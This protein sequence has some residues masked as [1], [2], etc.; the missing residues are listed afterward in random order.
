MQNGEV[1]ESARLFEAIGGVNDRIGEM[2]AYISQGD[3]EHSLEALDGVHK[4]NGG[5]SSFLAGLVYLAQ[6]DNKKAKP[7]MKKAAS[8]DMGSGVAD[9]YLG[10][11]H[12][13]T[14]TIPSAISAWEDASRKGMDIGFMGDNMAN[15]YHQL[16]YRYFDRGN[17]DRVIK[18]WEKLL[19][20]QP[21]DD[22]TRM[23]LVHAYFLR[24]NDYAESEQITYAIRYWEKAWELDS[25]NAEIAHNLALAY[26]KRNKLGE[27]TGYWKAAVNGWKKQMS[28]D[29][30]EKEILKARMYTVHIHLADIALK[31]DNV[32]RAIT[33]YRQAL[34]YSPEEVRT[35]VKLADLYMIEGGSN[36]A[37]QLLS[38]ARRLS[39]KDTDVLQQL[40]YAYVMNHDSIRSIECIKEIL[41]IDP[42]NKLYQEMLGYYYLARAK[43]ALDMGKQR[44][45]LNFLDEG[46]EVCPDDI[47]LRT[48]VGAVYLDMG[49]KSQ[50]EAAFQEVIDANPMETEPYVMVAHHYLD[51][52]M[53]DDAEAYFTK[54]IKLDPDNPHIYIDIAGEFCS[55]DICEY[56]QKYFGMAKKKGAGDA[57]VLIAIVELLMRHDC[58]EYGIQYAKELVSLAPDDPKSY[59]LL[60]LAYHLNDMDDEA[61]DMLI[62]A[63]SIKN[64]TSC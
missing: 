8:K 54:A 13:R 55:F 42:G 5:V 16:A 25:T 52:R 49:D 20:I 39:P 9:Y 7:L 56:A 30:G 41:K 59:F 29:K 33:E 62:Q 11:A 40:S 44:A 28:V 38:R 2:L 27:A 14:D 18:I 12:I 47:E 24:A 19:E 45:A 4:Q 51:N 26:E 37:I 34:R 43:D 50:A 35:I 46:L 32:G 53:V 64:G 3:Y 1:Q 6:G 15:I 21:E 31:V 58:S 61:M 48:F 63:I 22:E 17:L 36:K 60:A 23:N 10:V 57:N